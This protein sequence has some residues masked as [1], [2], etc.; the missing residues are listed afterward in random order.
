M[1]FTVLKSTLMDKLTPAMGTVSNKNTI[2]SIEG[3]LIETLDDGN[4]RLSTYDMNKG[5]RAVFTPSEIEREGKFIVN[6]QRLYQTLKVLPEQEITIDINDKLACTVSSGK[7]SFS[8]FAMNSDE[9]PVLPELTTDQGFEIQ[10]G[11]LKKMISKDIALEVN[12]STLWKG[13]G[14]AM[15]DREFLSLYKECGGRLITVGTDSH[16]PEHIGECVDEG[17]SL[18]RSVGLNDILVVRDGKKTVIKI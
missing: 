12:V 5:I 14:F 2:T 9:F 1:K 10:G 3:V 11:V 16:S 8:M 4:I 13:L 18:L 17:F 7:A 6:A 15:P